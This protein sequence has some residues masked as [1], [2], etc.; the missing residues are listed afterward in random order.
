MRP[1]HVRGADVAPRQDL[2]K[3]RPRRRWRSREL[4]EACAAHESTVERHDVFGSKRPGSPAGLCNTRRCGCSG[5]RTLRAVRAQTLPAPEARELTSPASK[6]LASPGRRNVREVR[7]V[8][9]RRRAVRPVSHLGVDDGLGVAL[10]RA[11]RCRRRPLR[12]ASSGISSKA[13]GL[14][15]L[16]RLPREARRA[17]LDRHTSAAFRIGR[18]AHAIRRALEISDGTISPIR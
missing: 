8:T 5:T 15:N 10:N 7:A 18:R 16:H 6:R 2:E 9:T 11:E 3:Q 13:D 17:Q 12:T 4:P 1:I 14:A